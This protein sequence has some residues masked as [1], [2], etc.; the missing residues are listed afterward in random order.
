MD[1]QLLAVLIAAGAAAVLLVGVVLAFADRRVVAVELESA[2]NAARAALHDVLT[3][4]PNRRHLFETLEELLA[5]QS[6]KFAL[7]AVDLDR[8]KPVNDLYGHAVGDQLL[9]KVARI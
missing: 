3:G 5:G 9:V 8:F 7:V 2:R 6:G 1:S 4:L